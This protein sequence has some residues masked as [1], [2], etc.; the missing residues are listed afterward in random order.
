MA[1]SRSHTSVIW[2]SVHRASPPFVKRESRFVLGPGSP[3]LGTGP[4]LLSCPDHNRGSALPMPS[5]LERLRNGLPPPFTVE[6]ELASG[7]MGTV[8][9]GRDESLDRPVA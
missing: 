6:R 7:G 3:A 5:V 1:S 8:F 2:P 4:Y 9:L